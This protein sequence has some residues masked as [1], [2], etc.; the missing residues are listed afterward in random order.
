MVKIRIVDVSRKKSVLLRKARRF[1]RGSTLISSGP[2]RIGKKKKVIVPGFALNVI[3]GTRI[4]KRR[5]R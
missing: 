1:P 5:R 4:M 3:A 2:I